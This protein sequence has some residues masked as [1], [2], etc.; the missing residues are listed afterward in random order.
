MVGYGGCCVKEVEA[1]LVV[2]VAIFFCSDF[3]CEERPHG[4]RIS[5]LG[6]ILGRIQSLGK[7]SLLVV[8]VSDIGNGDSMG[9]QEIPE[10]R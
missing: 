10:S 6:E 9:H 1:G 8:W 7:L 2:R 4:L 5:N 3:L